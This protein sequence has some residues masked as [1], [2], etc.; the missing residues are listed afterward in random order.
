MRIN[1]EV[2]EKTRN[3]RQKTFFNRFPY[4]SYA[5]RTDGS[6]LMQ[7]GHSPLFRDKTQLVF[8]MK[9]GGK[10]ERKKRSGG[11][12]GRAEHDRPLVEP[13]F[14]ISAMATVLLIACPIAFRTISLPGFSYTYD[15]NYFMSDGR[16]FF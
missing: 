12:S 1:L 16:Q 11:R 14:I 10:K 7:P 4:I 6:V 13:T 15:E 8:H 9:K 5:Y 3:V 2:P